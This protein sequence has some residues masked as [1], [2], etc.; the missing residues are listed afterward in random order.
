MEKLIMIEPKKW[1]EEAVSR[2]KEAFGPR[3]LYVGLQGSRQRGEANENSD[4]DLVTLLDEVSLADLDAHRAVTDALPEGGK[5]CGFICGIKDFAHWPRHELF[6]FQMDTRDYYG[7]LAD[8][9]PPLSRE[10][11]VLGVKISASTLLHALT[12]TYL[13]GAPDT[14]S[15]FMAEACKA[16]FFMLRT[17]AYL[18]SGQW[19]ATKKELLI[20]TLPDGERE[21]IQAS[22]NFAAW[23][24][25][26]T[27][28]HTPEILMALCREILRRQF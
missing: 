12:H 5:T 16:A 24:K 1:A 7:R 15:P 19:P 3:L 10:D 27:H 6:P 22:Q 17:K 25:A 28:G 9:M 26:H 8:F 18:K 21:I 13:Y 20:E 14:F 23:S 4:I 2:L 11:I